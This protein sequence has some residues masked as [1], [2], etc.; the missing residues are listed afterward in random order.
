M[1]AVP[2]VPAV[3]LEELKA[4]LRL[5]EPE[6]DALLAWLVRAATEAVE[7][8]LGRWLVARVATERRLVRDGS[9]RLRHGP[10]TGPVTA[11]L[12]DGGTLLTV[13]LVT[14]AQGQ[15]TALFD[16]VADG[17]AVD[18]SYVAGMGV[19]WTG[20]PETA[21]LAVVRTAAHFFQHR[22]A[23]EDGGLPAAAMRL[24][25]PLRVRRLG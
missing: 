2:G 21:R 16:G 9:V 3:L 19:D 6:E 10:V 4:W 13:T 17:A 25:A 8:E 7:A 20:M 23:I 15:G 14:G 1:A 24:L 12:A 22:D 18:L 11:A 5:E